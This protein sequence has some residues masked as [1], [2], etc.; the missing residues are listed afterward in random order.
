V[1]DFDCVVLAQASM[2]VAEPLLQNIGVP[3]VSSPV[4]AAK[5]AVEI[6]QSWD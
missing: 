1:H 2:H 5:R 3:V 6:A 4:M